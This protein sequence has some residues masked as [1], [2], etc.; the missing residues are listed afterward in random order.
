M[1]WI[2]ATQTYVSLGE[3]D[4]SATSV[5]TGLERAMDVAADTCRCCR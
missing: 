2:M 1:V 4:A 3:T 5:T